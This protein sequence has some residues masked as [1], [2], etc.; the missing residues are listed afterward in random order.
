M[1][2]KGGGIMEITLEKIDIIPWSENPAEFIAKAL[3][4]AEVVKTVITSL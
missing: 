2:R 1:K 3:A 4:P